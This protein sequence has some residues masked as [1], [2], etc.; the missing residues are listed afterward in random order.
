MSVSRETINDGGLRANGVFADTGTLLPE[1]HE[2]EFLHL[3][4]D[5][6]VDALSFPK[7][8]LIRNQSRPKLLGPD[9]EIRPDDLAQTGWGILFSA[10]MDSSSVEE[11]MSPLIEHRRAQTS[12]RRNDLFKIFRGNSGWRFGETAAE[13]LKRQG[14]PGPGLEVVNPRAGVPYYLLI[15]GSPDVIPMSFQYML[16]IFWAV[17]R[18]HFPTIEEYARYAVE[19]CRL[20][21]SA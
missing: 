6:I 19:R 8:P 13:W 11:A 7:Q 2:S 4:E 9:A 18:L 14:N 15:V 21:E 20:R 1:S 5:I 3:Y 16:D 10:D 17:G 12:R